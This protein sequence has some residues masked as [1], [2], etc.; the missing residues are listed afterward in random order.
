MSMEA[1]CHSGIAIS[2]VDAVQFGNSNLIPTHK[3]GF[4]MNASHFTA[5]GDDYICLCNVL[6]AKYSKQMITQP[7]AIRFSNKGFGLL[8]FTYNENTVILEQSLYDFR[9]SIYF[10]S[11]QN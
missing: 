10:E 9:N 5:I 4:G 2:A 6:R 1:T 8:N 11:V 3:S 7:V